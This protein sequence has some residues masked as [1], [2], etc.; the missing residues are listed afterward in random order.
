MMVSA[1]PI[2]GRP[3]ASPG[4]DDLADQVV[5]EVV[6][7]VV[8]HRDLLEHDLALGIEIVQVGA[9]TMPPTTFSAASTCAS[10]TRA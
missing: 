2:T 8:V 4:N 5:H 7:R 9:R 3:S 10:M 1:E 6:G